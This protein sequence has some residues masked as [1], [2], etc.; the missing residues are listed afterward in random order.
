MGN[1]LVKIGLIGGGFQ[2]APSS[3]LYKSPKYFIWEKN[4]ILNNTFWI[5]DSIISGIDCECKN[6]FA[7]LVESRDICPIS[8]DFVKN[9]IELVSKNYKYLF[10]HNKDIYKLAPNFIFVPPH[11]TW[12]EKPQI[13]S[14]SKLLSIISSNKNWTPGH[15]HRLN[16]VNKF[17]SKADLFGS[18]FRY[19]DKKED[20]LGPYY[21][22]IVIENDKYDSYFSE[23]ILDCF[24]C[25]TVPI[26]YGSS[27]IENH[28]DK[29]GIIT[30]DDNFDP[31][32]L[33]LELYKQM[34]PAIKNNLWIVQKDYNTI[35]DT[36]WSMIRN[37]LSF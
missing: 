2:H 28:F 34:L 21:F 30:L 12:I 29:N 31:S 36:L 5:D 15:I 6:K 13:F 32:Q 18:G 23:K 4:T 14:K 25:G 1:D 3:T 35:E 27:D 19:F 9:N 16:L 33:S 20:V 24:A 8:I 37:E 26:Y 22:S 7:W 10:T 11:G 17:K